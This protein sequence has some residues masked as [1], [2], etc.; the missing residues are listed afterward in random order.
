MILK[1]KRLKI[2]ELLLKWPKQNSRAPV[3]PMS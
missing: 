3:L 1:E 2:N